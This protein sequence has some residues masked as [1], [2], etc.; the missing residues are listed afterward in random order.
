VYIF[1]QKV[2]NMNLLQSVKSPKERDE[3]WSPFISSNGSG[4]SSKTNRHASSF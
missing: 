2:D 4:R 3:D 1:T